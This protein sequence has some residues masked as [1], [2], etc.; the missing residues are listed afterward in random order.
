[1]G[2]RNGVSLNYLEKTSNGVFMGLNS[3][4]KIERELPPSM[5][6]HIP[7]AKKL[8]TQLKKREKKVTS[9]RWDAEIELFSL[10]YSL[11][12]SKKPDV[13]V[14]TGVANGF[15]TNAIMK[16]I[17]ISKKNAQLH[18]FDVLPETKNAYLGKGKWVFHILPLRNTHTALSKKVN[19]L[20]KVD[21]WL[22][23]S[24]HGYRW[25]KFEFL[26]AL[27]R[28]TKNGILISDDIDASPAWAELAKTHFRKS[29]IVFDSRKFIGI[30]FK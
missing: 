12:R 7:A 22:H 27:S 17:E 20:P 19:D 5:S 23:D 2:D 13:I 18:S 26:L 24:N 8:F 9:V 1:L 10:L 4:L 11:V 3:L 6:R 25:Q 16:A 14:E 29:Y 28:L 30:A 15:S 21:I